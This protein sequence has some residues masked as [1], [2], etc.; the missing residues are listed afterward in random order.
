MN[1]LLKGIQIVTLALN[2]PGPLAAKRFVDLGATVIKVEPPEGDP[3]NKYCTDWYESVNHGQ[4]V[5]MINLKSSE[6]LEH[7]SALL[8]TTQLLIT[9]QRPAALERIGLDWASLHA[10]H[11]HLNHLA[12]VG[13]P[14][15]N[16]NHAGHDVTY[17]ASRGLLSPPHMPKTLVADLAGAERAAFE[18]LSM[19][20][21]S[22]VDG[23][24]RCSLVALSDAAD[25]MAQPYQFGL[26]NTGSLLSG[27]L[28]EYSLY[29]AKEGWVAIAAL[30]PHFRK[31]LLTQLGGSE[32]SKE[33]VAKKMK[34]KTANEWEQWAI[35]YD[36]PLVAVKS[37]D[38]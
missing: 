18:G 20:V 27:V 1:E 6:G 24:G 38:D 30:E 7:L 34:Q 23:Q 33:L 36:I 21:A 31:A 22:Q 12:V 25:Y 19:L 32:L 15:P 5:K 2:L 28:A 13:Y 16:E 4:Q 37:E 26:T 8:S 10:Q 35:Q 29:E 17:Q 14:V 11:P 9:A 3:F